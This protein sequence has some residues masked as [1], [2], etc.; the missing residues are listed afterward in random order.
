M[1]ASDYYDFLIPPFDRKD[2]ADMMGK[3]LFPTVEGLY[4]ALGY[5][6]FFGIARIILTHFVFQVSILFVSYYLSY[7]LSFC[8]FYSRWLD[9]V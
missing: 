9:F 2:L 3:N 8:K 5:A 7:L 4:P 6:I 1:V